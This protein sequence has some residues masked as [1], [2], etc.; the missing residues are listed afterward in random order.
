MLALVVL[1]ARESPEHGG[2][3]GVGRGELSF[4]PAQHSRVNK[5][6]A[7]GGGYRAVAQRLTNLLNLCSNPSSVTNLGNF[8]IL[9]Q[10]LFPHVKKGNDDTD[11]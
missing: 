8:L 2:M 1:V 11:S 10:T 3:C 5:R 7:G 4:C 9:S 6:M